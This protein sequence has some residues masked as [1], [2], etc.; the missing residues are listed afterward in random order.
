[1]ADAGGPAIAGGKKR[2]LNS[3]SGAFRGGAAENVSPDDHLEIARVSIGTGKIRNAVS[4][5]IPERLPCWG[6]GFLSR[7]VSLRAA[8]F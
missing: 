2:N 8:V 5:C 3:V 6:A 7:P 4:A 1:Y